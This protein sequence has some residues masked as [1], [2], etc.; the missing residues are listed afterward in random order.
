MFAMER[1]RIGVSV[2]DMYTKEIQMADKL[3]IGSFNVRGLADYN[4]RRKYFIT[5][6]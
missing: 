1:G 3:K 5:Y 6:I 4:K 2:K